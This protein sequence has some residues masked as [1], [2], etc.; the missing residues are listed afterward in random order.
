MY[1]KKEET[2]EIEN[3]KIMIFKKSWGKRVKNEWK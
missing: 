3:T 1:I 2:V